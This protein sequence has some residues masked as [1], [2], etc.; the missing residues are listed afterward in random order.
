MIMEGKKIYIKIFKKPDKDVYKPK[1][2]TL[3]KLM[4]EEEKQNA[5]IHETLMVHDSRFMVKVLW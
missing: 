4:T 2:G 5:G 1:R 3:S